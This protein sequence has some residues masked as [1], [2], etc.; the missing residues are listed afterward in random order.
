MPLTRVGLSCT[1]TTD[2]VCEKLIFNDTTGA[3][4][5]FTNTLGYGLPGGIA[6]TDVTSVNL[7][8]RFESAGF[9][10]TYL[11]TVASNVIT[12][13]TLSLNGATAVDITSELLSTAFPILIFNPLWDYGVTLPTLEDGVYSAEYTIAGNSSDVAFNY[14]TS[15]QV[16]TDCTVCCCNKKQFLNIDPNCADFEHKMDEAMSVLGWIQV[17]KSNA[18]YGNVDAAV[19]ALNKASELCDCGCGCGGDC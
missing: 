17:A 9:Y 6:S 18:E 3:Y 8:I 7:T 10:I 15:Q 5:A 4:N 13:A 12:A 1:L 16:V 11:F 19:E 2:D 14:T